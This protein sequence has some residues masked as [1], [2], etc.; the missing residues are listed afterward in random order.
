MIWHIRHFLVIMTLCLSMCLL[1]L[2]AFV[3]TQQIFIPRVF[4]HTLCSLEKYLPGELLITPQH[5][6]EV[7]TPLFHEAFPTS[8]PPLPSLRALLPSQS[9]SPLSRAQQ[10]EMIFSLVCFL[11]IGRFLVN[12]I[13]L[14][15][16]DGHTPVSLYSLLLCHGPRTLIRDV[17]VILSLELAIR[18]KWAYRGDTTEFQTSSSPHLS[19]VDTSTVWGRAPRVT[20]TI[21]RSLDWP[22]FCWRRAS[23]EICCEFTISVFTACLEDSTF[24]IFQFWCSSQPMVCDVLWSSR[25]WHECLDFYIFIFV[26]LVYI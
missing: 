15:F 8:P 24:S 6:A 26:C 22:S 21:G 23:T 14:Q 3:W 1:M 25:E 11:L 12:T 10:L 13:L 5:P 17:Y 4:I 19:A 2:C 20:P 16:H 7:T 18:A 9:T